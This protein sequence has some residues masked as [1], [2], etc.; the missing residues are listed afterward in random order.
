MVKLMLFFTYYLFIKDTEEFDK[1]KR[2][3]TIEKQ[4]IFVE[5]TKINK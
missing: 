1:T 3:N 4:T 2:N 5:I